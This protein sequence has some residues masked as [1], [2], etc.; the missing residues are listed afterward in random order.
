MGNV[1]YESLLHP[2]EFFQLSDLRVDAFGHGVKGASQLIEVI[3]TA[4]GQTLVK[5]ARR[6]PLS[7]LSRRAN[8]HDDLP[9]HNPRDHTKEPN[10]NDSRSQDRTTDKVERLLLLAERK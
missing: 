3:V 9:R 5:V 6:Q 4:N 2:G 8:R 1:R 10:Q 7:G